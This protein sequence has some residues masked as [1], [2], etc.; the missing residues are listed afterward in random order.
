MKTNAENFTGPRV[1]SCFINNIL[2]I[3][4]CF[5]GSYEDGQY[6]EGFGMIT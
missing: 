5:P 2:K 3:Y 6:S 4:T 1:A